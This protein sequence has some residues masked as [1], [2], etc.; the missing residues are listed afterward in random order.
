MIINYLLESWNSIRILFDYQSFNFFE[1]DKNLH[2]Q[3]F[4]IL[5][6]NDYSKIIT[7][8]YYSYIAIFVYYS[9]LC[10]FI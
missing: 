2:Y 8:V 9:I 5:E 4:E 6:E 7:I 1:S 3:S 10:I